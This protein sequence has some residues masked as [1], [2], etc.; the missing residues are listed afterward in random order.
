M[1]ATRL[2]A[3]LKYPSYSSIENWFRTFPGT[4]P[5]AWTATVPFEVGRPEYR[6]VLVLSWTEGDVMTPPVKTSPGMLSASAYSL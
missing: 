3:T 4:E 6:A 1:V 5:T 2:V